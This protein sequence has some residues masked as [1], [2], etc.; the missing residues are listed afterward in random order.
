MKIKLT[1]ENSKK[2]LKSAVDRQVIDDTEE[3]KQVF[4]AVNKVSDTEV[5]AIAETI[6]YAMCAKIHNR[7]I[8]EHLQ[9]SLDLNNE[10][11]TKRISQI[12]S[13]LL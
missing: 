5:I 12:L 3:F 4:N 13:V 1:S 9:E 2:L 7:K 10:T 8:K 6:Q 11:Y